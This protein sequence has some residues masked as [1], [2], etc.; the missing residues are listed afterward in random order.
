MKRIFFFSSPFSGSPC[1][2]QAGSHYV[3]FGLYTANLPRMYRK[4][5]LDIFFLPSVFLYAQ[6]TVRCNFIYLNELCQQMLPI[7]SVLLHKDGGR[8]VAFCL[9]RKQ[10]E[11]TRDVLASFLK[12]KLGFSVQIEAYHGTMQSQQLEIGY[13]FW[14]QNNAGFK[15]VVSTSAFGAGLDVRSGESPH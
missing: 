8:I 15:V 9:F 3:Q 4:T 10:R 6:T 7:C 14:N 2:L 12:D 5:L 13:A 1:D 11:T